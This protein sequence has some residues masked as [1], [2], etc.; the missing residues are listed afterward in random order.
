MTAAPQPLSKTDVE[1]LCLALPGVEKGTSWGDVPTFLV[2]GKGF[3]LF[4]HPHQTAVDEDGELM[5]D[6][7]VIH[8]SSEAEA[9]SLLDS[10][11]PFFTVEH[12]RSSPASVLVRER[13]LDQLEYLELAEVVTDA[14][15]GKAS[16]KLV[17]QHL[18]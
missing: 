9:R 6:V 5:D 11:L 12:F 16:K 1:D 2:G 7:I 18:G 8:T 4:R 3:V 17:K 13:D 15:A 10:E 14:W